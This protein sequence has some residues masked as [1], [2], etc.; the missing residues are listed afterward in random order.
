MQVKFLPKS[1]TFYFL[2]Y[3]LSNKIRGKHGFEWEYQRA[4]SGSTPNIKELYPTLT[5]ILIEFHELQK[6]RKFQIQ[7]WGI[8]IQIEASWAERQHQKQLRLMRQ[9]HPS[10]RKHLKKNSTGTAALESL[11]SKSSS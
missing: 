3:V 1:E 2:D 4:T 5:L 6:A 8:S 11:S 9:S 10:A 7:G